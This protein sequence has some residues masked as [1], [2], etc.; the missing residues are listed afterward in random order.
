MKKSTFVFF[1]LGIF[2]LLS[3]YIFA[4]ET[5]EIKGNIQDEQGEGN[6]NYLGLFG[7]HIY[8]P[9]FPELAETKAY[10]DLDLGG[11]VGWGIG[12]EGWCGEDSSPAKSGYRLSL[13]GNEK[14][15]AILLST[16]KIRCFF[17]F[18]LSLPFPLFSHSPFSI[19]YFP[20]FSLS[21]SICK[22]PTVFDV[23]RA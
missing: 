4:V 19:I 1:V 11:L 9:D 16:D 7:N 6:T 8:I 22:L 5:G 17:F 21:V 20:L 3:I 12:D 2:F 14:K 18:S 10:Y 13:S 23:T 15:I